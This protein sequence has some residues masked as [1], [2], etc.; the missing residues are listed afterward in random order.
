[1][2]LAIGPS[3]GH[4]GAMNLR[5]YL[6][7]HKIT[8]RQFGL[9]VDHSEAGVRKWLRGERVP[10]RATLKRIAAITGDAV[11]ATDFLDVPAPRTRAAA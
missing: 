1:M 7:Q 10:R 9:S 4:I 8:A 6:S 3:M 5:D 11:Q 2:G